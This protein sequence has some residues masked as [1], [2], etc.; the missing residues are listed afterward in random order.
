MREI[1]P[2]GTAGYEL[3]PKTSIKPVT[4]EINLTPLIPQRF[5]QVFKSPQSN[6]I[7]ELIQTIY[8]RIDDPD[9]HAGPRDGALHFP[10]QIPSQRTTRSSA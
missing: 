3:V 9:I 1:G 2:G 5:K 10:S 7:R 4:P 8:I 6:P